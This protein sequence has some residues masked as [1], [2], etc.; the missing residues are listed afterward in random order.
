[1]VKLSLRFLAVVIAIFLIIGF[2]RV[3]FSETITV[4]SAGSGTYK[5]AK[6]SASLN[7]D[8]Y[9]GGKN[10]INF[11]AQGLEPSDVYTVWLVK[12]SAAA[13]MTGLGDFPYLLKVD[14]SGR[15]AYTATVDAYKL[16]NWQDIKVMLHKDGDLQNLDKANL[17]T[18]F[19]ID[20]NELLSGKVKSSGAGSFNI[21]QSGS[22]QEQE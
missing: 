22:N 10:R 19:N 3:A 8:L 18:V 14:S 4:A 17:T 5:S 12:Q 11:Q 9:Y 1:M 13:P 6:I 15:V 16:N 2:S 20:I 7:Q 21:I